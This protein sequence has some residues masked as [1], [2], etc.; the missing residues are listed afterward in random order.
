MSLAAF[1]HKEVG[2]VG[3]DGRRPAYSTAPRARS[4]RR[5]A[6]VGLALFL[7]GCG[8]FAWWAKGRGYKTWM[9]ETAFPR[10]ALV[11]RTRPADGERGVLMN[12]FI[13]ADVSLPRFGSVIDAASLTTD[14]V[15]LYRADDGQ[16]IEAHVNTSGAGDSIV[17]QPLALLEPGTRYTFEV[18]PGVRDTKGTPFQPYKA[19]FTTSSV[20]ELME[21]PAAFEKVSL[22]HPQAIFTCVTFGPDG[23]L[24]A[25]SVDGRIVRWAINADGTLEAS[26]TIQTILAANNGPR[27]VIGIRFDPA[28]TADD[29][30]LWVTHGILGERDV[31]DFTSA[32]SRLSGPKLEKY[33]DY[34]VGLPRAHKDHLCNQLDFGPDDCIYF[35][36]GSNTGTGAPDKKWAGR[37]ERLLTAAML[38]V[39][40]RLITKPPL[41]VQTEG[42][43]LHKHYD[44]FAPGAPVTVYATGLRLGFDSLWHS[45]GHLFTGING[46]AAGGNTPGSDSVEPGSPGRIDIAERGPINAAKVPALFEIGARPDFL[47]LIEKGGYYGHPNPR[48]HELVL[49]GGNP[50]A[51]EDIAEVP[52]YPVGTTPDRNWRKPAVAL[53]R[54]V[55]PNGMIEYKGD[56][57]GGALDG[58]ILLTRYSGGDDLVALAVGAEGQITEM[59]VG[60]EG[61]RGFLDPLD[62]TQDPRSGALYVSEYSGSKLTLLRPLK[63]AQGRA[64]NSTKA[65]RMKIDPETRQAVR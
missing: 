41:N 26:E 19:T 63:D 62:I 30:A 61:F 16:P 43:G 50:T 53:G 28:A 4:R 24:Y 65:L 21:F 7:A 27:M 51:G 9:L 11:M 44:P 57:F 36:Q 55:S 8:A 10:P 3:D 47:L 49:D 14:N 13:A 5:R 48:R 56:A 18:T 2:F 6:I 23:K 1:G 54:N 52:E 59:I 64:V 22:A 15:K 34:V 58:K 31:P 37:Y 39:D 42:K 29:L 20:V 17:L 25:A 45:S 12:E 33:Q 32:L 60:I 40:P 35:T 46:S 38:R